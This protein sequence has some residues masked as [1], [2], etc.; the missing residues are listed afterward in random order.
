[1]QKRRLFF[2]IPV[3]AVFGLSFIVMLLWN[4]IITDITTFNQVTYWQAM[5]LLLLCKILFG[6]RGPGRR[7]GGF[8]KQRNLRNR[9]MNMSDDEKEKLRSWCRR[10]NEG[11]DDRAGA[12]K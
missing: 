4:N 2:L 8:G 5:G 6:F 12:V 9:M 1:M 11:F 10:R 7:G 3:V